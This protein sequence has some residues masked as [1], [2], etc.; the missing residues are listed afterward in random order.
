MATVCNFAVIWR[1]NLFWGSL[2]LIHKL[3]P[4]LWEKMVSV[5]RE[6]FMYLFCFQYR[7]HYMNWYNLWWM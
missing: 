4:V 2:D 6:D 7:H 1:L 5:I 3:E